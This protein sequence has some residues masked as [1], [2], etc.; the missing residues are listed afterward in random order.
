[1]KLTFAC[2][3][4]ILSCAT[5]AQDTTLL[6][7]RAKAVDA[8]F[9]GSSIGGARVMVHDAVTG[10]LLAEGVTTG[11]TGDTELIMKTPRKRR[12][13]I[14]TEATS[15]FLAKVLIERPTKVNVTVIAPQNNGN[16]KITASTAL[17]M[18]PGKNILGDGLVVYIHGFAVDILSPQTHEVIEGTKEIEVKANIVLMC[19]CPVQ[20]D[21]IW[22]SNDYTLIAHLK[23]DGEIIQESPLTYTGKSSTFQANFAVE[24]NGNF[25]VEVIAFDENTANTGYSIVGFI[26]RE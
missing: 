15:A 11:S 10:A 3:L 5:Y 23:K 7:I 21:G 19:G 6:T 20:P 25:E 26:I 4:M 22:D 9:I 17:W 14:S 24:E 13:Q 8:K 2:L 18:F 12:Q 16:A 1:M